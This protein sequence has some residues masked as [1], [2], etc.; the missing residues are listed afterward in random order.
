MYRVISS[1]R[2]GLE[3]NRVLCRQIR[4]NRFHL[5]PIAYRI[6]YKRI[7]VKTSIGFK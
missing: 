2:W 7:T 1:D 4:I 6:A 5:S 3:L